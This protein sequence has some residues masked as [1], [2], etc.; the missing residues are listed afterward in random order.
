LDK[1]FKRGNQLYKTMIFRHVSVMNLKNFLPLLPVLLLVGCSTTATF[2]RM[3][4]TQQ[5]RNAD[6]LYPVEVAFDSSEQA[7][8]WDSL[9]PFVLVQG[10]AFPL[11]QVPLVK[12]RWEGLVPVPPGANTVSYRF[13]FDYLYNTFGSNPKPNSVSSKV[14]TLKVVD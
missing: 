4:P 8:R 6:N 3:T 9:R 14:Y 10:Q 7:L 5:P 13:K 11:R 12:N 1:P 2:T